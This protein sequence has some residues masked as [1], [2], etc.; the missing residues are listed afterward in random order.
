[1]SDFKVGDKV[2][3]VPRGL[4]LDGINPGDQ[5][6]VVDVHGGWVYCLFPG[7]N[8]PAALLSSELTSID[9]AQE[10]RRLMDEHDRVLKIHN[11]TFA[12]LDTLRK[13]I[14]VIELEILETI[15]G[16]K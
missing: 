6:D 4:M 2:R 16:A 9:R 15:R 3:F 7:R 13:Q 12:Q 8:D 5:G 10:Y 11:E 14:D 1:M